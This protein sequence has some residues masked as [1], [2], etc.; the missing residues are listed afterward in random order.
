MT[1][2]VHD[3]RGVRIL[4]LVVVLSAC[5]ATSERH[6]TRHPP[7]STSPTSGGVTS[8]TSA[9]PTSGVR[10]VLT[11]VG[12]NVRAQPST[13]ATV[14]RT[15][16]RGAVLNVLAH[17]DQ[18]GGWFEVRGPTVTG[19]ISDDPTLSAAGSFTSYSSTAHQVSLLYPEGWTVAES[20]PAS[21]VF[22][23][24]SGSDTMVVSTAS[25]VDQLAHGRSGYQRTA[26]EQVVVCGVT[27][28]LV[29]YIRAGSPLTTTPPTGVVAEHVL[30]Q[31]NLT[32]DPQHALGFDA[33]LADASQLTTFRAVVDS[34][35]FPFPQ[36]QSAGA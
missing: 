12:L 30:A 21:V 1:G 20:G 6:A 35:T 34:V 8:T 17:S 36:C 32:L 7:S 26:S 2:R 5:S 9:A 22:H 31:V 14:L 19:W 24:P 33:N 18:S 16:A 27:T 13:T 28:D 23:P 15:A 11:P 29:T 25:T 10:T 4:A 3:V